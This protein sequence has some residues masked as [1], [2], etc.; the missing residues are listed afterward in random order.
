MAYC[1]PFTKH[2]LARTLGDD[3]A[4]QVLCVRGVVCDADGKEPVSALIK[5]TKNYISIMSGEYKN[6]DSDKV[7]K[8]FEV[9]YG[10]REAAHTA[11]RVLKHDFDREF[12]T[13]NKPTV[14][15]QDRIFQPAYSCYVRFGGYGEF[16]TSK[17]A[18][19]EE[20]ARVYGDLH[21]MMNTHF[22]TPRMGMSHSVFLNFARYDSA[23]NFVQDA[24]NGKIFL[25]GQNI[26][27]RPQR[28]LGF[29]MSLV[30]RLQEDGRCEFSLAQARAFRARKSDMAIDDIAHV[31]KHVDTHFLYDAKRDIYHFLPLSAPVELATLPKISSIPQARCSKV[32][33]EL[34]FAQILRTATSKAT[35]PRNL[36]NKTS[37]VEDKTATINGNPIAENQ[38]EEDTVCNKEDVVDHVNDSDT[39]L[40]L[41]H[42]KLNV[43]TENDSDRQLSPLME[44]GNEAHDIQEEPAC[45]EP[46][47][48]VIDVVWKSQSPELIED[49]LSH[50][51]IQGE[52]ECDQDSHTFWDLT[53]PEL[54]E[55]FE[56]AGLPAVGIRHSL[57]TGNDMWSLIHSE[58]AMEN[59]IAPPPV[60]LGFHH[61]LVYNIKMR[62]AVSDAYGIVLPEHDLRDVL[63]TPPLYT[64]ML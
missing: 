60:G 57:F 38:Q 1:P 62:K 41:E 55:F 29:I 64:D 6:E 34:S 11:I 49:V 53:H 20:M 32:T 63:W 56:Q 4:P 31:L 10:T 30:E 45:P 36:H 19:V 46:I 18:L 58:N 44:F 33:A 3:S 39:L 22:N 24:N 43:K 54:C 27:A 15:S 9:I 50:S 12:T 26:I 42:N 48:D 51:T 16:D 7:Y 61:C 5:Q 59:F 40:V 37:N 17:P 52:E 35:P 8:R 47:K 23:F 2:P 25:N 13:E 28:N 14:V 21:S